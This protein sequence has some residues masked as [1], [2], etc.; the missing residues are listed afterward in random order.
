MKCQQVMLKN[1]KYA[2]ACYINVF[3]EHFY[4]IDFPDPLAEGAQMLYKSLKF[5]Q[6]I[7]K[8]NCPGVILYI[9]LLAEGDFDSGVLL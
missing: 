5:L 8:D 6:N 3:V 9:N 1:V 7:K 2:F 4:D